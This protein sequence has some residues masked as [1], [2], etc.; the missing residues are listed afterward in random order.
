MRAG[1]PGFLSGSLSMPSGIARSERRDEGPA[2]NAAALGRL[3]RR[4]VLAQLAL[5]APAGVLLLVGLIVPLCWLLVQSFIGAD[6]GLSFE[7]YERIYQKEHHALFLATTFEI[8][9]L[10]TLICNLIGYP[11]AY[12]VVMLPRAFARLVAVAIVL[13]FFC[14]LLVRSYS[15][16]ILLQRRGIV[17]SF[18]IDSGLTDEPLSLVYNFGGT[19][20]GTTHILLP[21]FVLPLISSMTAINR[22]YLRAAA[23]MGASPF[24]SFWSIFFPLSLPGLFAGSVLVFVLSL[25]FYITPALLGGG[26]IVVWATAVAQ[27][28]DSDPVWGRAAALGVVLLLVTM[29]S[30]FLLKKLFRVD[31]LMNRAGG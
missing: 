12:A 20:V 2:V 30:L 21:L 14:S 10:V 17:N 13:S 29:L 24:T 9:V 19:L 27:A 8:A 23:S 28:A 1:E 25:G 3:A 5:L 4:K 16:L 7:H 11:L 18:L 26:K 31:N 22:D 15:W 6:G